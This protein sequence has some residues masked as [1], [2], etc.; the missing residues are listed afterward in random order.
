VDSN[1]YHCKGYSG[2]ID[3]RIFARALS[4]LSS[5]ALLARRITTSCTVLI[6]PPGFTLNANPNTGSLVSGQGFK[7][8]HYTQF[9]QHEPVAQR[10][11]RLSGKASLAGANKIQAGSLCYFT[12]LPSRG[13]Y[14]EALAG[15][16]PYLARQSGEQSSIGFQ[17]VFVGTTERYF[18]VPAVSPNCV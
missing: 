15:G 3:R 13:G 5:T 14:A 4:T 1:V 10:H 8:D 9:C 18:Q 6:F 11:Y 12:P 16:F 7:P 2:S 17:P